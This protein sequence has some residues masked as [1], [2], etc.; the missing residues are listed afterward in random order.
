MEPADVPTLLKS[1]LPGVLKRNSYIFSNGLVPHAPRRTHSLL[2]YRYAT[3]VRPSAHFTHSPL[4]APSSP[5]LVPLSLACALPPFC[6][7]RL[8]ARLDQTA[9]ACPGCTASR[10]CFTAGSRPVSFSQ[11]DA[12]M[13]LTKPANTKAMPHV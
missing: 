8:D 4:P 5:P 12:E 7:P 1:S 10:P 13:P 2:A 6:A 3:L 11:V 9:G